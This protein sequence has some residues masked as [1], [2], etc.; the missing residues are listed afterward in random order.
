M[1]FTVYKSS[2]GS[3]KTYTLVREYLKIILAEPKDFRKVLAITFTNKAANEMK[4]RILS[5]L[6]DLS[7]F[8]SSSDAIAVKF[9]LP[10]LIE[11]TKLDEKKIS[12]NAEK[13]LQLI[14]HNYSDFGVSTIDSF[15]HKIIRTFA[16]D[17]HLPLNFEVEMDSDE[18]IAKA[19]DIL[20]SNVGTDKALTDVLV[21]FTKYKTEGE[22]SWHIERDLADISKKILTDE[23]QSHIEKLKELSLQDFSGI[24]HNLESAVK[25]F[26]KKIVGFANSA[27]KLIADQGLS[28]V[29]FYQGARGIYNYFDK[30]AAGKFDK[31]RPNK[32]VVKTIE[33]DKW[34]SAKAS[35]PDK[36]SID[37]IKNGLV[38]AFQEIETLIEKEYPV[39]LVRNEVLKNLYPLALLNEIEKVLEEY[40]EDNE[41]IHISEFNKRIAEIVLKEPIPFIYERMGEKYKH[42]MLDEFQDTS[43]LQWLNLLPLLENSLA[44][45]NFNMLVGDGKQA[46]YRWRGGEVEQFSRLPEI[47]NKENDPLLE[48]RAQSLKRNYKEESLGSNF[49]SKAEIIQFN[50]DFFRVISEN[51]SDNLHS[52]Y[53]KLEQGF[54]SNNT[55][56]AVQIKFLPT[57]NIEFSIEELHLEEILSVIG[58]VRDDGFRLKDVAILCR[59]NKKASLAAT[60]LLQNNI[61]VISS[62][63]LLINN[64]AEVRFLFAFVKCM[65]NHSDYIAQVE[66]VSYLYNKKAIEGGL[67]KLIMKL[68]GNANQENG[69]WGLLKS[70]GFKFQP[71]SLLALPAYDLFEELIREFGLNK[72]VDPYLQFLLDAILDVSVQKFQGISEILEWWEKK[73]G[74]L[75]IVVPEGVD[76]VR[77][78]PTH[79]AKGL[80]FPVVVYPFANEK[81]RR[82]NDK[83]WIEPNDKEVPNLKTALVNTSKW[84]EETAFGHQYREEDDKSLLDLINLLYVTL[85]RPTDRLYVISPM[86]PVKTS[87]IHS[88]PQFFK[89]FLQEKGL[90]DDEKGL[91][92]WGNPE[93]KNPDEGKS[94]VQ[95]D[96][97]LDKFVSVPWRNRM[98]LSLQAPEHWDVD[99]VSDS[100]EYGRLVHSILSKIIT[101]DDVPSVIGQLSN[102]GVIGESEADEISATINEV[103]QKPEVSRFFKKG[104]KVKTEAGIMGK[105]GK[106]YRPD[107]VV[108]T[109][110]EVSV[111]DFKTG[112]REDKHQSQLTKYKD[113][114][115]EMNY[116]NV[117][118]FLLYLNEDVGLVEV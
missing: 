59:D 88:V 26:E 1:S 30:L 67:H 74:K 117:K 14:L 60:Y 98:L 113:L 5:S 87:S 61:N 97:S 13:C 111:I 7:A 116:A 109:E 40:K 17:M 66:V 94:I 79:K 104:L 27:F 75:S 73:K 8:E 108:I 64:S 45:D 69:F 118:G 85:T 93:P 35:A 36:A 2:A 76:A 114:L 38:S 19:V 44:E 89:Q 39:Y 81:Q 24:R 46:I 77:V 29:A 22:K 106:S 57:E 33:E 72:D 28:A 100:V 49:R 70:N 4:Q 110:N 105:N 58:E 21:N 9:M 15:V 90:W 12:R 84:M 96:F 80:E 43:V 112:K 103:L 51:L 55:G 91:Y 32:N 25:S 92:K 52:I 48:E 41:I 47:I 11:E 99:G 42:F 115:L 86:P 18:L 53:D 63:S 37:S 78:M 23:G 50:N 56:G 16:H 3:G 6:Q 95:A 54:D 68:T 71:E 10:E 83:L 107:R 101:I 20:I 62:E 34:T 65:L 31:I 102:D 82:S